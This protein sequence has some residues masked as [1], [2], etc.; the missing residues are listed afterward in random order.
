MKKFLLACCAVV[1]WASATQA[2]AQDANYTVKPGDLL[3]ISVARPT[4]DDV[5]LTLTGHA[6]E[7]PVA[8][9][10]APKSKPRM[11]Q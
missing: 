3:S 10:P 4:L 7:T 1:A 9:P 2:L 8:T 5:F 6:A 11:A